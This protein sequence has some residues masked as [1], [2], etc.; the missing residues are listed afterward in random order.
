MRA[1]AREGGSTSQWNWCAENRADWEQAEALEKH[2]LAVRERVL[3]ASHWH[4]ALSLNTLGSIYMQT[5]RE[6][7]AV[8]LLRRSVE[9]SKQTWTAHP[10]RWYSERLLASALV[11][12][13]Q[14]GE[15]IALLDRQAEALATLEEPLVQALGLEIRV[16]ALVAEEQYAAAESDAR[17]A[18]ELFE[19]E[20][21]ER[22][23]VVRHLVLI[24]NKLGQQ[25][26]A[27]AWAEH[28]RELEK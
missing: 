4:V 26:E 28:L 25:E 27:E 11:A 5:Q 13:K 18:L 8:E 12:T 17:K 9:I 7:D 10:D 21:P 24:L 14:H 16:A 19:A 6:Q 22:C 1:L 3:G 23:E 15:V 2:S 20:V